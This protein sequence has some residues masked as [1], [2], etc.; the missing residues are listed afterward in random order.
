MLLL[1]LK[2]MVFFFYLGQTKETKHQVVQKFRYLIQSRFESILDNIL[3]KSDVVRAH[4]VLW[5]ISQEVLTA[6]S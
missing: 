3:S 4:E 2:K 6:S 1:C 5:D